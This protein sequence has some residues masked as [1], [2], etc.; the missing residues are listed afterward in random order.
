MMTTVNEVILFYLLLLVGHVAH[1]F[2]EVWGRVWLI[3][4]FFHSLGRFLAANLFIFSIP[5]VVFYFILQDMRWAYFMGI[6]YAGVM[7]LNGI[8]YN[9]ATAIT[10]RYFNGFAGGYSGIFLVLFGTLL[11]FYLIRG[12]TNN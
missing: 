10:K 5:M 11:V 7:V 3:D 8:G 12:V 6:V 1:V 2:E 4:G 9:L